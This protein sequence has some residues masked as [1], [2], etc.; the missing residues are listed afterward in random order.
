MAL[1]WGKIPLVRFCPPGQRCLPFPLS[2][3]SRTHT[4]LIPHFSFSVLCLVDSRPGLFEMWALRRKN[5]P[6]C[7]CVCVLSETKKV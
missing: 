1:P 6:Y 7:V 4:F 3:F 2:V 5:P